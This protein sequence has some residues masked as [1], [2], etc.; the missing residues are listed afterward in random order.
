MQQMSREEF[1]LWLEDNREEALS[2][3][4]DES[5]TPHEWISGMAGSLKTIA[6][7]EFDTDDDDYDEDDGDDD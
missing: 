5:M 7:E 2:R 4:D 1:E 6:S 3:I